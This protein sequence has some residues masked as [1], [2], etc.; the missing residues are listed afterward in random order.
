[1][2]GTYSNGVSHI[3]QV[4]DLTYFSRSQS[5]GQSLLCT[6]Q[7]MC[8]QPRGH[9]CVC[10]VFFLFFPWPESSV[11][12]PGWG[13]SCCDFVSPFFFLRHKVHSF[14]SGSGGGLYC[15]FANPFFPL[16][17]KIIDHSFFFPLVGRFLLL[18]CKFFF[19]F[20][21]HKAHSFF[22]PWWGRFLL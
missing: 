9:E 22:F 4:F 7:L 19:F 14:F 17:A 11:F 20:P 3:I 1:M 16:A 2:V 6:G 15:D 21:G 8:S 18:F 10:K 5:S 13:D 12:F